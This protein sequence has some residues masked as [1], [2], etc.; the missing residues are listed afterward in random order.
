MVAAIRMF[1]AWINLEEETVHLALVDTMEQ[2]TLVAFQAATLP[3]STVAP[4][5]NPTLAI[6]T[7]HSGL[8]KFAK[9]QPV[10]Q[11]ANTLEGVLPQ[12]SVIATALVTLDQDV[13]HSLVILHVKTMECALDLINVIA[14]GQTSL[15]ADAT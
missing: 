7:I 13:N 3:V 10:I 14:L 5:F 12:T 1:C 6:A 11:N 15:V 2:E 4:A 9:C 8:V